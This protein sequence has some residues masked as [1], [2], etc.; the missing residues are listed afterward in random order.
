[1]CSVFVVVMPWLPVA[2]FLYFL[3]FFFLSSSCPNRLP[4]DS[5]PRM[6]RMRTRRS[7]RSNNN[8]YLRSQCTQSFGYFQLISECPKYEN[9]EMQH[10]SLLIYCAQNLYA[11]YVSY[12]HMNRIWRQPHKIMK[13]IILSISRRAAYVNLEKKCVMCDLCSLEFVLCTLH[14]LQANDRNL[15]LITFLLFIMDYKN[16]QCNKIFFKYYNNILHSKSI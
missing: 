4:F 1:M 5:N 15:C 13:Y 11:L 9:I 8:I 6:K 12:P 2:I 10:A 3:L 7:N 16:K 14:I